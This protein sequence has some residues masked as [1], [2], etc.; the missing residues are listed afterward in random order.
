MRKADR[1]FG[2]GFSLIEVIVASII[3][4]SAVVALCAVG[5][6]SMTGVKRNRDYETAWE[7]IDRQLTMIEYIG[8]EEFIELGKLEGQ[9]G[10]E[11]EPGPVHYWSVQLEEGDL[12]N[13]YDVRLTVSWGSKTRSRSIAAS[14][15]FNGLGLLEETEE[16][17]EES[18]EENQD[19]QEN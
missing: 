8:I 2:K 4:S 1:K 9:F 6:K 11:D 7:Q 14:T 5:N 13:I 18:E 16:E 12:D 3:L 19:S 10:D 15:R 17:T